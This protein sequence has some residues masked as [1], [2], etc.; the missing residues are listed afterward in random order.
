VNAPS[1]SVV[2]G[3]YRRERFL[4]E[5]VESI[6]AQTIPRAQ[7]EIVVTKDF[8]SE[9]I[10]R[11]LTAHG[12]T[13]LQDDDPHIGPWLSRAVAAT[14][15]PWVAFLDDDDRFEPRRLARVL[16]VVS[17]HPDLGYYRNRVAVIDVAGEPIAPHR[18]AAHEV[19]GALDGSGPLWVAS[20]EKT[21]N[22]PA[23]ERLHPLFN[24]SSIVVQR[25]ILSGEMADRFLE[26]QNP[27]PLLFLAGLVA[28]CGM[29][30][31][32][33]RLTLYRRHPENITKTLWALRH[34]FEDS[35]RLAEIAERRAPP[36]YASW[37]RARSV[38]I[39]KRLWSEGISAGLLASVPRKELISLSTGYLRFLGRHPEERALD[40]ATWAAPAYA[41]ASV[42]FPGLARGVRRA[43][44]QLRG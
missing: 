8:V 12:V 27:D 39:E 6:L 26:T 14:H 2:V 28:P 19:D 16:E 31:D 21:A 10:D 17:A 9:P 30:F 11:F 4:R 5:A 44:A 3:A 41:A 37:L 38:H 15:A 43:A 1:I 18:W 32:D 22:F 42:V 13:V 40:A 23:V 36:P 35:R 24:S 20:S 29:F 25:E 34:G 33:Q 7:V